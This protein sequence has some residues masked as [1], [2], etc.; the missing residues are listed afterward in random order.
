MNQ[1][2]VEMGQ[3][4]VLIERERGAQ[5]FERFVDFTTL[6]MRLAEQDVKLRSVFTDGHHLFDDA[7]CLI[8]LA[9]LYQGERKRIV[10]CRVLRLRGHDFSQ[11]RRRTR[12]VAGCEIA[13]SEQLLDADVR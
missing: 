1:T 8:E 6:V 13:E 4:Y 12:I 3:P 9:V 11:Q 2:C 10:E 7:I 5:L